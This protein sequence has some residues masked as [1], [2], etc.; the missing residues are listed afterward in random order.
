MTRFTQML[1]VVTLFILAVG[2]STPPALAH[3]SL[4]PVHGGVVQL[5]GE[6]SFELVARPDGVEVYLIYDAEDLSS[7]G[8]TGNIKVSKDGAVTSAKLEPAGGNKLVGKGVSLSS[9]ARALVFITLKDG[10]TRSSARFTIK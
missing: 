6:M 7:D 2:G 9:G 5:V 1:A 3:G 10:V 4:K 8:I